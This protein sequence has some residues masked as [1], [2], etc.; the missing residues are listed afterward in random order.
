MSI[1]NCCYLRDSR[2]RFMEPEVEEEEEDDDDEQKKLSTT[3]LLRDKDNDE[4]LSTIFD[5]GTTS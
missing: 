4:I 1:R 5:F 2:D 3:K